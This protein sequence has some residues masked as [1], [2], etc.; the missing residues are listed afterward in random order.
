MYSMPPLVFKKDC[1]THILTH[2]TL[3]N[4]RNSSEGYISHGSSGYL[5]EVGL[6]E[7]GQGRE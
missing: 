1:Y 3:A 5:W 6:G 4:T 2:N 7:G